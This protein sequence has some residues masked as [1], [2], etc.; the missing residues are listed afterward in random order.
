MSTEVVYDLDFFGEWSGHRRSFNCL[1]ITK[2]RPAM[3][4]ESSPSVAE[5]LREHL[6]SVS[7]NLLRAMVKTFA[8]VLMSA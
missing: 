2:Q 8:D 6:E 5:L 3:A 1:K 7:L 4:A